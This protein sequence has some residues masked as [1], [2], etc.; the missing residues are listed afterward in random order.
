[1]IQDDPL[2]FL[3]QNGPEVIFDEAQKLPELFSYIQVISDE[4]NTPGQ[5]ILS[6]SQSFLLSEKISQSL[7]GRVNINHLY[8]FDLLEF[9]SFN[10]ENP[11]ELIVS[12]FYPRLHNQKISPGDFYPSYLQTYIEKDIRTLKNVENLRNFSRFISL[13][14]GRIGQPLNLTSLANDTGISVNTA[15]SWISLLESSFIIFLLQPYYKNFNKR[16]TKSPK[17]YFYDTGVAASLLKI[18]GSEQLFTHY[19]YGSLFENLVVSEIIK[20]CQHLGK[21]YSIY[22]WRESNGTEIDCILEIENRTIALEIKSGQTFTKEYLKNLKIFSKEKT[23]QN[24]EK[25][26]IYNGDDSMMVSDIELLNWK[27]FPGFLK[28]L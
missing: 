25:K 18:A 6:G 21:Q 23:Q 1:M 22:Y 27:Q 16:L 17:L 26:I 4:R 9:L 10:S 14:A 13:C 8:P 7:A 3:R 28:N 20:T 24:F 15:K 5:Y 12:G 19:M 11:A 2:G